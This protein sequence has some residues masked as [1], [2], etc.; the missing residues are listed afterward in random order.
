MTQITNPMALPILWSFRRCPYAM[1]ARLAIKS[2]GRNVLLREILLRDKPAPFLEAS[3]KG[4]VPVL[5]LPD[6]TVIDESLD[7]MFW[8]LE[9][10]DPEDWMAPLSAN[11]DESRAHLNSLDIE[12]K[13]HLDRYK[14]ATRYDGVDEGEHR[15]KGVEFLNKWNKMLG[16]TGALSGEKLG[17]LDYATL[18]FVRQ[19]RIADLDWFDRQDWPHLHQ[20]LQSFL[21]SERFDMIMKKYKPWLETG[22]DI[23]F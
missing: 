1:R 13:H 3:E 8:A 7:V 12:F 6:G 23:T 9:G 4:T 5:I 2:S 22:E 10:S 17:F 14:Y 11:E 18:P 15:D 20:W 21:A 16:Q 19:F